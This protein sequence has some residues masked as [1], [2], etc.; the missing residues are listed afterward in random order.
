[1]AAAEVLDGPVVRRWFALAADALAHGSAVIDGLNVFPVPDADTG[2]NLH[3][4]V[5]SAARAVAAVPGSAPVAELWRAATEAALTG[6]YGNSGMI[7]SQLLRGLADDCAR[8]ASCDGGVLAVAL[9]SAAR[10]ARSAVRHPVEG[11][12]LTVADAAAA[13]ASGTATGLADVA[14]AAADGGRRALADTRGQ[15]AVL[16]VSGVVDAGGAGLCVLLDALSAAVS[17][18]AAGAGPGR[19]PVFSLLAG[20]DGAAAAPA[21]AA[22]GGRHQPVPQLPPQALDA[23]AGPAGAGQPQHGY[24]VTFLLTAGRRA[25]GEL[26]DRLDGLGDSLVVTGGERQ[27]HV[28]VHVPDAGPVLEQAMA[29]GPV[30]RIT[31]SYLGGHPAP[32][33]AHRAVVVAEGPALAE[34]LADAGALTVPIASPVQ[35]IAAVAVHDPQRDPAADAAAMASAAAGMRYGS[36]RPGPPCTGL[37]GDRVIARGDDPVQVAGVVTAALC[38]PGTELVTVLSGATCGPELAGLVAAQ[39][40]QASPQADVVCYDGGMSGAIVLIGAE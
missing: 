34:L 11:T 32:P 30:R 29:A 23:S 18:P 8:A 9:G 14:A 33:A 21:M 10:L 4:T 38:G 27:W 3:R 7:V 36:V 1:M 13:A 12:V 16:A 26:A 2:T 17:G 6:A 22:A 28:H 20:L 37:V 15:L 31:V 39:A 35:A 5:S 25:V 24:E 19:L 40:R